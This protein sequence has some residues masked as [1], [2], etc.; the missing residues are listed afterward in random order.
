M[1]QEDCEEFRDLICRLLPGLGICEVAKPSGQRIVYFGEFVSPATEEHQLWG[2][3]VVK[4]SSGISPAVI[5]Y[6]QREIRTLNEL[7]SDYYPKLHFD[8]VYTEDPDTEDKLEERLFVT[9][10]ERIQS[11]PLAECSSSYSTEQQVR[12][13]LTELV[14]ALRL[15]WEQKPP[16]V[17]RDIKPENILIKDDGSVVIIDLGIVREEGAAGVTKTEALWGPCT[18]HFSSPEQA[19]N[20]KRNITFKSDIFELGI[21][22]YELIS[23][24]NPFRPSSDMSIV[25]VLGNV[26][27]HDPSPLK[28]ISDVSDEFAALISRMMQKEPYRRPRTPDSLLESLDRLQEKHNGD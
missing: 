18:P 20:D 4:V 9:V 6:L 7:D 19:R 15:L 14:C 23:G 22:A 13:L 28:D 25:D 17:H 10:E 16:L 2:D 24:S 21:L 8:D 26:I 27:N 12:V 1:S 5:S 11:V 3:V